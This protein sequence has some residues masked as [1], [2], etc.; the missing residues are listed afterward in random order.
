MF[1][2]RNKTKRRVFMRL[3]NRVNKIK[4][5]KISRPL[6]MSSRMYNKYVS[7]DNRQSNLISRKKHYKPNKNIQLGVIPNTIPKIS[8]NHRPSLMYTQSK[9]RRTNS[10]S[11]YTLGRTM[12]R[13]RNHNN[14]TRKIN[15]NLTSMMDTFTN[16]TGCKSCRGA[17]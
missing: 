8:L 2:L 10:Q 6:F 4:T 9:N 3:P 15:R 17:V 5:T 11:R 7:I 13:N 1:P 16:T 14:Y 12:N